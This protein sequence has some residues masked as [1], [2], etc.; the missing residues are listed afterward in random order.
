MTNIKLQERRLISANDDA[1]SQ[2]LDLDKAK[3]ELASG[4]IV[5]GKY[6]FSI[7]IFSDS[8]DDISKKTNDIITDLTNKGFLITGSSIALP[9]T[10]FSQFPANFG[11]IPR[12]HTV[13]S[14]N[15]ASFL[16]L[17]SFPTGRKNNNQWGE[18]LTIFK[19]PSK[20]PYFF[21][22][23][24]VR[25]GFNDFGEA[26]L[27]NTLIL[28]QSGGGK[29][30]LMNFL[31]NQLDKYTNLDTFPKNTPIEKKKAI[32]FYLDKDK[33]AIGNIIAS[34]GKY[35]T[36]NAGKSTGF[37]PF[38]V[39]TTAEN[40]RRIQALMKMLV[41]RNG[42]I[43]STLEEENLNNAVNSVMKHFK[44]EDRK[45]GI[46]LML[47]H[48]TED[49]TETNSMKSRLKLWSKDKQ[50]GWVFD[51]EVDELNFN[52]NN[53]SVYGI[54]GTDLLK[55]NEISSFV[56]Y[57]MLWRIM[58]LADG[59]RFVLF[60]DEAW[61]WLRNSVVANE[62]FNKEKTIRKQNG[63]LV[64]GTQSVEDLAK[65]SIAT[66]LIEQSET[67]LL[68]SNP[69]ANLE[70]YKRL[71]MTKEEFDFVKLINPNLYLFLVKKGVNERAIVSMNLSSI[72]SEN[73]KI[74]ST[75]T[76]FVDYIEKINNSNIPYKEK[77]A[78]IKELYRSK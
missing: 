51:N 31:L 46:S 77:L 24:K 27:G 74:L 5:F 6:H 16:A 73:L 32:F 39:D 78:K 33:G 30:V 14:L 57:Y 22:F 45:F 69:Q 10:Y 12:V 15:F 52:D 59:R 53:I 62:V 25:D 54:D 72:G 26:L 65:S 66:A 21:N 55:D 76:E 63:L 58:D 28:G 2:I 36:I 23:H 50:F 11:I 42:E 35:I 19:T 9:A 71:S 3:D 67:I 7:M 41:T 49:I 38:M 44:K 13:S 64:L 4:E 47:E 70:D 1:K 29:T 43:L 20:Q 75:K 8:K 17:H 34:G 60:I 37:N 48:L 56:A 18:A 40:I 68:L 61:D